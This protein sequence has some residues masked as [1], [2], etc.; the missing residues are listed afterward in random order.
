MY[1]GPTCKRTRKRRNRLKGGWSTASIDILA[2]KYLKKPER[3]ADIC[4]YVIFQGEPVIHAKDVRYQGTEKTA[5]PYEQEEQPWPV[6][7]SRDILIRG[8]VRSAL[9]SFTFV[10]GVENQ[11]HVHYAMP[12]KTMIY[13][14]IDYV[15]QVEK[16]D[17]KKEWKDSDEFLSS[18]TRRDKIHPVLTVTLYLGPGEWDGPRDLYHM[19]DTDEEVILNLI[20]NYTL[21]LIVPHDMSE[22][23]LG[24]FHSDL[25]IVLKAIKVSENK[26]ALK[27]VVHAD[28]RYE[29]MKSDAFMLLQEI[30]GKRLIKRTKGGVFDMCKALDDLWKDGVKEGKANLE[31]V[32]KELEAERK[33]RRM[34]EDSIKDIV[35]SLLQGGQSV[36]EV[37][38]H[39]SHSE[40]WVRKTARECGI[41]LVRGRAVQA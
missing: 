15:E 10:M 8:T 38:E 34:A 17:R 27:E 36:R 13:D 7:R 1:N 23:E 39:T 35:K 12:V 25:G 22:E 14:A 28:S 3:I 19:F 30:L 37:S 18:F 4:N 40:N 11:S 32:K 21:H 5:V 16:V 29:Q 20:S 33:K 9:V 2:K 41:T 24:H 26:D 6:K 31:E